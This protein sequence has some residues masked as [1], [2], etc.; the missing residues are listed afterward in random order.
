MIIEL[1][2]IKK[3]VK[4]QA[5]TRIKIFSILLKDNIIPK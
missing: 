3:T 2:P 4:N 5:K 1:Q